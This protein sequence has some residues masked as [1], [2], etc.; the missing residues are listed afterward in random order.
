MIKQKEL[1]KNYINKYDKSPISILKNINLEVQDGEMIA[2]IGRSGV[3][4]STL[5]NI[6]SGLEYASS[7]EYYFNDINIRSLEKKQLLEWRKKNIGF[8]LQNYGLI[9]TDT[10][11][12]NIS[13]P[14][15]YNRTNSNNIK[16]KT[17]TLI[18][19]LELNQKENSYI[20]NLSGGECQRVAIAR[21]LV[22]NPKLILADE[23]TGALDKESE[24]IVINLLKE[25]ANQGTSIIIVT[26]DLSLAQQCDRILELRAGVLTPILNTSL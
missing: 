16:E 19:K 7:G 3:G 2:L 21:S 9:S 8:I 5:L 23:P 6:L 25:Y 22:N 15:L 14:L 12:D 26:H 1:Q 4:K 13:L 17:M 10:V 20:Y 18:E 11:F 24:K